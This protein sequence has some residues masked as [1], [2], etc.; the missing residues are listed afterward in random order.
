MSW[1]IEAEE[2]LKQLT[3]IQGQT[4]FGIPVQQTWTALYM[5]EK[6]ITNQKIEQIFELGTGDGA[7]SLFF[8]YRD[9]RFWTYD[10]KNNQD[11]FSAKIINEIKFYLKVNWNSKSMVFCDNG[12][13]PREIR[14][15]A[16]LLKPGDFILAHDYRRPD[17]VPEN[18][19]YKS[20]GLETYRQPEWD[21]LKTYILCLRKK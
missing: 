12:D 21:K 11:V 16:P 9:E 13:K 7:L 20:L 5:L 6:L 17:G 2:N 3:N 1:M 18:F 19:D 10:I 4:L 15:Y 8:G 14:T